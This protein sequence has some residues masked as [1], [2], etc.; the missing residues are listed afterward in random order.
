[1]S[2]RT[3]IV[4][5]AAHGIGLATAHALSA[6]GFDVVAVDS[7]KNL[8]ISEAK[9]DENAPPKRVGTFNYFTG[10]DPGAVIP[11]AP[12][13]ASYSIIRVIK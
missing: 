12:Q 7:D 3:A 5:G 6:A 8:F 2:R 1:M 10:G 9:F 11:V 13:D 4:T